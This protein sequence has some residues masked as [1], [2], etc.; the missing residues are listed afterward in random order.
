MRLLFY[1]Y[2]LLVEFSLTLLANCIINEVIQEFHGF[3]YALLASVA[4]GG[5][6]SQLISC[7]LFD[8]LYLIV[9]DIRPSKQ[10]D[11][12]LDG[13]IPELVDLV[14]VDIDESGG[15]LKFIFVTLYV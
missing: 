1:L 11:D 9:G 13:A 14:I 8:Y 15:R 5:E 12:F 2:R 7:M 3:I 10:L 4:L 6:P